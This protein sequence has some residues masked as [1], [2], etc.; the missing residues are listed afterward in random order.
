MTR[1]V[2]LVFGRCDGSTVGLGQPA[3]PTIGDAQERGYQQ[4]RADDE[5][6]LVPT[7]LM[8]ED[9]PDDRT[10]WGN[11]SRVQV[12]LDERTRDTNQERRE[13]PCPR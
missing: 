9:H 10:V 5:Q 13:H 2:S 3:G 7:A 6:R 12:V 1:S 11:I 4:Q 8:C